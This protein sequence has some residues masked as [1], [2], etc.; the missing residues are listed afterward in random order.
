[1]FA[2]ASSTFDCKTLKRK[3]KKTP[4][5]VLCQHHRLP[6]FFHFGRNCTETRSGCTF[7]PRF[8][9]DTNRALLVH[10]GQH[11][12]NVGREQIV[13]LVAEGGFAEQLR[14]A[15]QIADRH[16]EVGVTGG[17]VRDARERMRYQDVL[18]KESSDQ[19]IR[20]LE[21]DLLQAIAH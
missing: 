15:H 18:W 8:L 12:R 11:E 6:F 4:L 3:T 9:L 7:F 21:G 1:M 20:W 16:V 14:A 5:K 17:P 13:H 19:C 10:V 2:T